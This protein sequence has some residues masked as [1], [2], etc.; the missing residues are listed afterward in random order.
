M[1]GKKKKERRAW[2][3]HWLSQPRTTPVPF[4]AYGVRCCVIRSDE[5]VGKK[6]EN[7]ISL[8]KA[9]HF[10]P[11]HSSQTNPSQQP[12]ELLNDV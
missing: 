2:L 4:G 12:Q 3:L 5:D 8:Q 1:E 7:A 6:A 11:I 10:H 9:A